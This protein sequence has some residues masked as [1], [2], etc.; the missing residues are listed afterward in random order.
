MLILSNFKHESNFKECSGGATDE[1]LNTSRQNVGSTEE[2]ESS[3]SSSGKFIIIWKWDSCIIWFE[4]NVANAVPT[5][6]TDTLLGVELFQVGGAFMK[7]L[8]RALV[9]FI[10]KSLLPLS[11]VDNPNFMAFIKC[12]DARINF[13][14]RNTI[15][16]THLP[17]LY[18]EARLKLIHELEKVD[19][20]AL[21]TDCWTSLSNYSYLT[22]TVHYISDKMKM[23]S[24][25]LST[26][27]ACLSMI[28]YLL[29]SF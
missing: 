3:S 24:R 12:I 15:T 25:V 19:Y 14:C 29:I 7:R 16:Y 23:V 9:I 26:V 22:I 11:I 21:T 5:E 17:E 10:A 18:E 28:N 20:V 13:T 4:I 2:K 27:S 8:M 6:A 1:V